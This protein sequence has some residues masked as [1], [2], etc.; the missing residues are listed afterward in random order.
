M[1]Q[2]LHRELTYYLRGLGFRIH[3]VLGGGHPESNYEA[4][5]VAGLEADHIP[6]RHQSKYY[7][8]YRNQQVGEYRPDFTLADGALQLDLK[9]TPRILA[10]HKAQL[11]SYLAVTQAE[12]GLI[13]NFGAG[14]M[15]YERL[16]NFLE[17][18]PRVA[19]PITPNEHWLYFA[20]TRQVLD[21]L[22]AVHGTLGPGFL[23][24]VYRRATR[25]ELAHQG[26]AFTYV[27]ELPV[28][29][30][31]QVLD[32]RPTRLFIVE[33]KLLVATVALAQIK[34]THSERLR[35]AQRETGCPLGLIANFYPSALDIRFYRLG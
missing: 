19:L 32:T 29:Y 30:N 28:R 15:Q 33:Q 9:A 2:L 8:Y 18:R 4:A 10:L 14:S 13:M 27:Q 26:L 34:P 16:P 7:V 24:Q 6:F 35:W 11:L 22:Y 12:L 5:M 31:G 17:G 1:T 21:A 20:L 25:I 23:H 3:K